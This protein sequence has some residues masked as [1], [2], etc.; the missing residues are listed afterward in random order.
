MQGGRMEKKK[1]VASF[2]K[3]EG[4]VYRIILEAEDQEDAEIQGDKIARNS[5]Y[6][7][8][9]VEAEVRSPIPRVLP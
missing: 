7:K 9:R 5:G 4:G 1:F 3:P 6:V 2:D 8:K